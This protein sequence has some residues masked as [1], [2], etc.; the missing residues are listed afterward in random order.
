MSAKKESIYYASAQE[1]MLS[2]EHAARRR[3]GMKIL[4]VGRDPTLFGG[5]VCLFKPACRAS[6]RKEQT[7]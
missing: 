7:I 6:E 5:G 3:R 2:A 4:A 1:K